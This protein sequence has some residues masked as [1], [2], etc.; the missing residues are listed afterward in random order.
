[1]K[2]IQWIR[3]NEENLVLSFFGAASLIADAALLISIF[4]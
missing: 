4:R 1:M 3:E 2:I